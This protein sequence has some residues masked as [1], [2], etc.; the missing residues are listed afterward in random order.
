MK[1]S[2]AITLISL[3]LTIIVILIISTIT[4]NMV[5]G[6][7]GIIRNVNNAKEQT[8]IDNEKEII[9]RAT[10]NAIGGNKYGD[11]QEA[12]LQNQLDKEQE[13]KTDVSDIG[14]SFEIVF[15]ETNRIYNVDKDGN[16]SEPLNFI[17]DNFPGDITKGK[18]GENLDGSE[19]KP[20][21]I[22]CI[23]DLIEFSK[24]YYSYRRAYI[25]LKRDLNF[26]SRFSYND[27]E[28]VSYG[29]INQD[30]ETTSL[31]KEMQGGV[32]FTPVEIFQ[33]T[34]LGEDF[35]IDN[36]YVNVSGNAGLIAM[37]DGARVK[38]LTIS[39][40]II[41]E[42]GN[43]G[44]IC[45]YS[46][47]SGIY[48]Q[49]CKNYASILAKKE[50]A[51]GFAGWGGNTIEECTNYGN[52]Q[53]LGSDRTNINYTTGVAGGIVGTG[54]GFIKNCYNYGDISG[55]LSAGGIRGYQYSGNSNIINSFNKGT[56]Q[57]KVCTGGILGE[58]KA[59]TVT[60]S[61]SYNLGNVEGEDYV[62]GLVGYKY[63][64]TTTNIYN[65][66]NLGD[67]KGSVT[68]RTGDILG[69]Y[70]G[71]AGAYESYI[72]TAK[73]VYCKK[74]NNQPIGNSSRVEIN[75]KELNDI[76]SSAFAEELNSNIEELKSEE[77]DTSDWEKWSLGEN[78]YPTFEE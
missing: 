66:Y 30:G 51:G 40:T 35:R 74:S 13:G 12:E 38:Q 20:Y 65:S 9:K 64:N 63:Y 72:V 77:I 47:V 28:T 54:S 42:S 57:G 17:K 73:K 68:N 10:V 50:A 19:E 70:A 3:V 33:G 45:G 39:G 15:K 46:K 43:V 78:G 58:T 7:N 32:G 53:S 27:S 8:E 22:W 26:K 44:G 29:D 31:I 34:F 55:N 1:N 59:G 2:K 61:N 71:G 16:V 56:V 14:D 5:T 6:D 69:F 48:I 11:L 25:K 49:R 4:I 24:N 41:S 18:D 67:V 60:I 37:G 21:E 36:L 52:V 62:G 23:E 76:K 75:I